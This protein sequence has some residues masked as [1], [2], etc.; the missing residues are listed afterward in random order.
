[1]QD[2]KRGKKMNIRNSEGYYDPTAYEAIKN[3]ERE[4]NMQV[5]RGDIYFIKK[6]NINSGS[7]QENGRPAIVVSNNTGNANADVVEVVYTTLQVKT[8]LPTHVQVVARVKS[9]ALCE[10]IFTVSKDRLQEFVRSCTEKEMEQIDK[11]LMISL[12]IK[13]PEQATKEVIKEVVREVPAEVTQAEREAMIKL[14]AERD[15]FKGLYDEMFKK[16]CGD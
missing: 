5:K 12:G 10:Q 13:Q 2:I 6:T 11:A 9:T 3:A 4:R 15:I 7:E 8:P 1:M 14:Q 16:I